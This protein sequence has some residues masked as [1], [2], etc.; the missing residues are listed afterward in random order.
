MRRGRGGDLLVEGVAE[1]VEGVDGAV[2]LQGT[3]GRRVTKYLVNSYRVPYLSSR[4]RVWMVLFTCRAQGGGEWGEGGPFTGRA[5]NLWRE[6][7]GRVGGGRRAVY[8][9]GHE[10]MA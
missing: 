5:I 4:T 2:H 1:Q 9:Q 6:R 3:K 7:G 10:F 8:R